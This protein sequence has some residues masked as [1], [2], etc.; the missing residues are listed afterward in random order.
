MTVVPPPVKPTQLNS[1]AAFGLPRKL[2]GTGT[3]RL[4]IVQLRQVGRQGTQAANID[5]KQGQ[6]RVTYS[7]KT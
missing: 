5:K 7:R 1:P 2:A 6:D 3:N 4:F